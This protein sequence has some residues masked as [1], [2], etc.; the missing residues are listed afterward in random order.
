M[1][2]DPGPA[3]A[4]PVPG[5]L[6]HQIGLHRLRS[7]GAEYPQPGAPVPVGIVLHGSAAIVLYPVMIRRDTEHEAILRHGRQCHALNWLIVHGDPYPSVGGHMVAHGQPHPVTGSRHRQIPVEAHA[8]SALILTDHGLTLH[9]LCGL[10]PRLAL[11]LILIEEGPV[12]LIEAKKLP[13]A[14]PGPHTVAVIVLGGGPPEVGPGYHIYELPA[15]VAVGCDAPLAVGELHREIIP[16]HAQIVITADHP[17]RPV[18]G[19]HALHVYAADRLPPGY[20]MSGPRPRGIC[21]K[22]EGD[23]DHILAPGLR[24]LCP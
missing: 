6:R 2:S 5:L 10:R 14:I 3:H 17:Q 11:G 9:E 7:R 12:I 1:I 16:V 8:H 21:L 20:L 22:P 19:H 4:G 15:A 23:G 24:R 18:R 13:Y